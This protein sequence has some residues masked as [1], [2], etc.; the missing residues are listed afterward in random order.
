[1]NRIASLAAVPLV[2]FALVGCSQSAATADAH[3]TACRT[4]RLEVAGQDQGLAMLMRDAV[5]TSGWDNQL[6]NHAINQVKV[7]VAAAGRT[8]GLAQQDFDVYGQLADELGKAYTLLNPTADSNFVFGRAA[9]HSY[10]TAL[11]HV[12]SLCSD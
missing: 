11:A 12:R 5:R 3:P 7:A 6:M 1:M 4:Y 9:A 2:G 8:P 10:T